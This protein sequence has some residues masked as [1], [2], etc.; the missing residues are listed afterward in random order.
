MGM[1]LGRGGRGGDQGMNSAM[2]LG[3]L[4]PSTGR[5]EHHPAEIPQN[6][7]AVIAIVLET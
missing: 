6:Q 7:A 4:S 1:Q 2:W 5:S 3:P